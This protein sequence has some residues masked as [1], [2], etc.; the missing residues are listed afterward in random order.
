MKT[1]FKIDFVNFNKLDDETLKLVWKWRTSDLIRS[2]MTDQRVFSLEE[3]M[4]FCSKLK[5]RRDVL[6]VLVYCNDTPVGV[7]TYKD[8]DPISHSCV[9]GCY[10]VNAPKNVSSLVSTMMGAY[11][12]KQGI[13]VFRTIVLK[14]NIQSLLFNTLKCNYKIVREDNLYYYLENDFSK[15]D[16]EIQKNKADYAKAL[17]QNNKVKFNI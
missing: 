15:L 4:E 5:N 2:K 16:E 17:L 9:P 14:N 6:F 8:I 7:L 11:L 1:N 13:Y 3:H 10:F 12:H